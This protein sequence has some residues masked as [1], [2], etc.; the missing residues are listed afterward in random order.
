MQ[1]YNQL[2]KAEIEK[3]FASHQG[4]QGEEEK[5]QYIMREDSEIAK[6]Y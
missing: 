1:K 4:E 6:L 5:L 3:K 2:R